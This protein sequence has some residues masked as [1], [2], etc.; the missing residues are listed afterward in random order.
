MLASPS[1]PDSRFD[2]IASHVNTSKDDLITLFRPQVS[3]QRLYCMRSSLTC[4]LLSMVAKGCG[5]FYSFIP[6]IS[7]LSAPRKSY[8]SANIMTNSL[9]S[10]LRSVSISLKWDLLSGWALSYSCV[11]SPC[12]CRC[13]LF[14]RIP[15]TLTSPGLELLAN[16]EVIC[17]A[18]TYDF[19]ILIRGICNM[20]TFRLCYE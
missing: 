14:Q 7:L 19:A 11:V 16:S 1:D 8:L 2:L 3:K 4:R 6:S 10:A 5:R 12:C 13:W 20:Q 15:I 9:R 17:S 18:I